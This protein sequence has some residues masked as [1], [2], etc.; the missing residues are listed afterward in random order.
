MPRLTIPATPNKPAPHRASLQPLLEL[1][2]PLSTVSDGSPLICLGTLSM[3]YW[4]LSPSILPGVKYSQTTYQPGVSA[5]MVSSLLH[6]SKPALSSR[7]CTKRPG[8]KEE[9]SLFLPAQFVLPQPTVVVLL[10]TN[11]VKCPV[12]SLNPGFAQ[13]YSSPSRPHASTEAL[14]FA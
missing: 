8:A 9:H 13:L 4:L 2:I 12:A 1:V 6:S 11:C 10:Q 5:V 7:H 3:K 14:A